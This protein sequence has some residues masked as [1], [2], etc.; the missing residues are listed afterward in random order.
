MALRRAA[1]LGLLAVLTTAAGLVATAPAAHAAT[2]D[3]YVAK[4]GADHVGHNRHNDCRQKAHPCRTIDHAIKE[5][6]SGDTI[7][8][9]PGTFHESLVVPRSL[10]FVGAGASGRRKTVVEG[11]GDRS[12]SFVFANTKKD[13]VDYAIRAIAVDDNVADHAI[14]ATGNVQLTVS[15]ASV[16]NNTGGD[17][18]DVRFGVSVKIV[19]STILGND[20]D[21]V[22]GYQDVSVNLTG[23]TVSNNQY[24]GVEL[25]SSNSTA[26]IDGSTITSNQD[27][28]I[29]VYDGKN[30]ARRSGAAAAALHIERAS[31]TVIN[32]SV[33]DNGGGGVEI[34]VANAS[35]TISGST[36]DGNHRD[37]AHVSATS[38]PPKGAAADPEPPLQITDSDMSSNGRSG[39]YSTSPTSITGSTVDHNGGNGLEFV[40]RGA[41]TIDT[42]S[43]HANTGAG[44]DVYGAESNATISRSAVTGTVPYDFGDEHYDGAGIEVFLGVASV[45]HSTLAGNSGQGLLDVAGAATIEN[46]TITG[47]TPSRDAGYTSGGVVFRPSLRVGSTKAARSAVGNVARTRMISGARASSADPPL[48]VTGSIVAAQHEGAVPDCDGVVL[49]GG[50]NLSSD[51]ANSCRFAAARHDLV[52]TDPELGRL[53]DNGGLTVT[54]APLEHSPAIDRIPSGAAGCVRGATDQRKVGGPQPA[55]GRCDVGAVELAAKVLAIGPR[56]L[57]HARVGKPYSQ[58]LTATGGQFP[59]HAFAL[60]TGPMPRGLHLDPDGRITG[61]PTRP[62]TYRI[63]VRVNGAARKSYAVVIDKAAVSGIGA[64]VALAATVGAGAVLAGFLLF[65]AP[66]RARRSHARHRRS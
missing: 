35:T 63:V 13:P 37:G 38:G 31:V 40:G 15:N 28:G 1:G 47:T 56:S 27:N 5:A 48:T 17:G 64:H 26:M 49:D 53:K 44:I 22:L 62:G 24:E 65:V 41:A 23:T 8:I 25:A 58:T 36:V 4:G 10:T 34:Y 54:E 6:A 59:S 21:G 42:S 60:A 50:Y 52:R 14:E 20:G 29:R 32:S 66:R 30:L 19:D 18:I 3:R 45:V 2:V 46:S 12:A 33:S 39:A 9:G 55:G 51:T 11:N 61:T 57:P 43:F 7:D 16:S